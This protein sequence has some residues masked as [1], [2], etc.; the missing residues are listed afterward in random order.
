ML[1]SMIWTSASSRKKREKDSPYP[2]K[3]EGE[4]VIQKKEKR[5]SYGNPQNFHT[6]AYPDQIA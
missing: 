4:K 6:L 1:K 3:G 5:S 2:K